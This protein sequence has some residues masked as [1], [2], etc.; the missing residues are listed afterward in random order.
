MALAAP[1]PALAEGLDLSAGAGGIT[2]PLG[3]SLFATAGYGKLLWGED[4]LAGARSDE[5]RYGYVRPWMGV[6]TSLFNNRADAGVDLFPVSILG[7]RA[8]ASL[9]SR[10]ID[11]STIDCSV[12]AC[13]GRVSR[14]FARG[15]LTLGYWNL[16]LKSWFGAE[17]LNPSVEDRVF[18]DEYNAIVG[19]RGG[20]TELTF[21][22]ALGA[23][24]GWSR[25][26]VHFF[27]GRML[28]EGT[29]FRMADLFHS[30]S[31]KPGFNVTAGAGVFESSHR[32]LSP[33]AYFL[34]QWTGA[35]SLELGS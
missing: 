2:Q 25:G 32:A 5:F 34:L 14:L 1:V 15:V 21:E 13:R 17:R 8:G 10:H 29:S 30:F 3:A 33:T 11:P 35:P 19:H 7:V 28:A 24:L 4:N 22:A 23:N 20:D 6:R 26:G 9:S 18:S 27:A 31:P 16:F 12:A